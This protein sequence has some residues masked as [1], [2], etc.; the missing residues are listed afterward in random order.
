MIYYVSVHEYTSV[1]YSSI[2]SNI[3]I[4][5]G[6]LPNCKLSNT[7]DCLKQKYFIKTVFIPLN[8]KS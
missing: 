7:L 3:E 4:P 2:L 8:Y 1:W 5:K 6:R